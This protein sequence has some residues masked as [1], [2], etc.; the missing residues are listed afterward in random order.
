MP[1]TVSAVPTGLLDRAGLGISAL[2]R[3]TTI[4]PSSKTK[5]RATRCA[6]QNNGVVSLEEVKGRNRDEQDKGH[7]HPGDRQ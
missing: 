4:A 5:V 1:N 6:F 2:K 7:G 3:P